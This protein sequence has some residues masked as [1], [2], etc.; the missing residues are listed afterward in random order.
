MCDLVRVGEG[1]R[2][3][4]GVGIVCGEGV[5]GLEVGIVQTGVVVRVLSVVQVCYGRAA[6]TVWCGRSWRRAIGKS[7][8]GGCA[9]VGNGRRR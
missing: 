9:L 4:V 5:M 2:G 8:R 6:R 1:G 3:G 7:I